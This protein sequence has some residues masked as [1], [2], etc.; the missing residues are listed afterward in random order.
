MRDPVR[1][2]GLFASL[3]RLL[4]TVLQMAQVRLQL[5]GTEVELEKR[6]LFDG[7]L[8]GGAALVVLG[9]GLVLLCGFVI[10]LFWEGYRLAAVGGMTVLFLV[11]GTLMLRHARYRLS[12]RNDSKGMFEASLAELKRDQADLNGAGQHEAR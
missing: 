7:L 6:R 11:G 10:L 5:L 2:S 3:S 12:N 8:W 4:A 9:L 1:E